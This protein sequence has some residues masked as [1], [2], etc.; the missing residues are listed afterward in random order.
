MSARPPAPPAAVPSLP[1]PTAMRLLRAAVAATVLAAA[2]AGAQ[3]PTVLNFDASPTATAAGAFGA[4]GGYT[5][6]NFATLEASS[7]FGTGTNAVSGARFAYVVLQPGAV[8]FGSVYRENLNWNLLDAF[9]SF[10]TFDGNTAPL[11]ITV[12]AYRGFT[13]DDPVFTR[14]L[15]L[16]NAAQRFTFDWRDISEVEFLPD[17]TGSGRPAVLAVDDLTV[18]AVPEPATVVLVGAGAV[19]LL[20]AGA[21]RRRSA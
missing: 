14:D 17:P 6:A 16:T 15:V 5:F 11:T 3:Q 21:R 20:G 13:D 12:N 18:A 8:P 2:P 7:P 9:L 19:V 4:A 1:A 10:R